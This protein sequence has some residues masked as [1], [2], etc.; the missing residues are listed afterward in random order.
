M[1]APTLHV[2]CLGTKKWGRGS[3]SDTDHGGFQY[4]V[5][6][7]PQSD[8]DMD[9]RQKQIRQY[10]KLLLFSQSKP[11]NYLIIIWM[12]PFLMSTKI[13]YIWAF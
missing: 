4:E 12:F 11:H 2:W 8:L 6:H 7:M 5:R 9:Y 13:L 1:P 10:L 3:V